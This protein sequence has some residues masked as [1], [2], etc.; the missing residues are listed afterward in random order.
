MGALGS[1][2]CLV[3]ACCLGESPLGPRDG[4]GVVAS[5]K[6]EPAHLLEQL[7]ALDRIAVLAQPLEA[8]LEAGAGALAITGFPVQS[9]D[10]AVQ[11]RC[12][13]AIAERSQTR[14]GRPRNGRERRCAAR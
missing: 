4:A 9:T 5:T 1:I 6:G 3:F 13:R 8:R 11:A 10:L 7:R 2:C 14:P 12:T